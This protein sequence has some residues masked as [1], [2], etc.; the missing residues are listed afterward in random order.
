MNFYDV[1]LKR[2]SKLQRLTFLCIKTSK[3]WKTPRNIKKKYFLNKLY[4]SLTTLF[5]IASV[6]WLWVSNGDGPNV[7]VILF[8]FW[9]VRFQG[10]R[11]DLTK[12]IPYL[13]SI[14]IA[15]CT[16][17]TICLRFSWCWYI[18]PTITIFAVNFKCHSFQISTKCW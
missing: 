11:K 10:F 14:L 5:F 17:I 18:S 8:Y 3:L 13:H 9:L 1:H 4:H 15:R 7:K 16:C 12:N 6:Q 2:K